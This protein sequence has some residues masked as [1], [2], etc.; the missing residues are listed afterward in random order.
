MVFETAF[1]D[2][3][4]VQPNSTPEEL[5]KAYRKLA[6]KYHPDK[7]PN[8]GEKF[9]QISMAYEVLSDPEKKA[10]YDAGG[11]NAIKQ[12]SGGGGGFHSPMDIFHMFFNGGFTGRKSERKSSNLIHTLGVTLEELYTGT[13]RKLVLQ[14]NVI[15][16]TCEGIG[17][18]RGASQ[19][20]APCRGTGVITKVQKIAP[21]LVQQC[22]ER[23]RNCRGLGETID[24]KDRC[25]ECNGRKTVRVRKLLEVEVFQGMMDE[26]RI[27]LQGEG[28]QEPDHRPG[29]IV[30]VLEEKPHA[31]FKRNGQDL[32]AHVE[33]QLSEA[34]CGFRKVIKT[35]DGRDIVI[36][37]YPGE[38]VKNFSTKCVMGEGMPSLNV[39]TEKGR[40][41]IQFVVT[42][43]D[44]L[45]PEIVPEI[46]KC[47]PNLPPEPIPEDCEEV[48]MIELTEE[49]YQMMNDDDED[50][51]DSGRLPGH[52][53]ERAHMQACNSS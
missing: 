41:I 35:L 3:L 4:G 51:Q 31:V 19:K 50:S 25:K 48:E 11:E 28:D 43:P 53:G 8:E 33:L 24:D 37:T 34:L 1:Y 49:Q 18:K 6:L 17:G 12:G 14:K 30:L 40:L 13:K 32:L 21:G 46:R 36:Q 5:K 38:V 42:F 47:L 39:P 10:I 22:E 2:I 44:S 7:N 52:G 27:V 15:C 29:D 9:K 26:Q 45:P 23:C 20:C 16:E